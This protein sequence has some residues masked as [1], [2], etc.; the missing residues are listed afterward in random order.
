MPPIPINVIHRPC[1]I[2]EITVAIAKDSA[3][4]RATYLFEILG[5]LEVAVEVG[6]VQL[7]GGERWDQ[8]GLNLGELLKLVR[9]EVQRGVLL[10]GL[11]V[12]LEIFDVFDQL[13]EF[14]QP[15][16]FFNG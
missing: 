4:I 10:E 2:Q 1:E 3:R 15:L 5:F 16:H 8:S 13:L 7:C 6:E 14:L 11:N 9:V 12:H